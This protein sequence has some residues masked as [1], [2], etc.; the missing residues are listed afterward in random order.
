M[1]YLALDH[2]SSLTFSGGSVE[3]INKSKATTFAEFWPR[4][5]ADHSLPGT[6][7]LH[8]LGLAAG[9]GCAAVLASK[10]KWA[11]LPFALI[12]G[13]AA[14][15]AGHFLVQRNKPAS[16]EHPLWSFIADYKMAGLML[17]S[18]MDD[19]IKRL[20]ENELPSVRNS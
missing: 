14:A 17:T 5:V 16:F 12:P 13:Y 2:V 1:G 7:A 4:Y 19:E 15:W 8:L 11:L 3:T 20:G 10:R 18:R 9:L 6:R